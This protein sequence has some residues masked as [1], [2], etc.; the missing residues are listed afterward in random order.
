MS[1]PV[2]RGRAR[3]ARAFTVLVLALTLTAASVTTSQAHEHDPEE[4][5][6]PVRV[7][8]YILHPIGVILDFVLVRPAHWLVSH[9]PFQTLFGHEPDE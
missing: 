6:H 3:L 7:I 9:E 5:G 2:A 4:S 8:A 1:D